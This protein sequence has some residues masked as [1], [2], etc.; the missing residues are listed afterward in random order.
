[1]SRYTGSARHKALAAFIVEKRMTAGLRQVDLA[2]R[3]K[4][5]QS[6]VTHIETGQKEVGVVELMEL[7][8]AIG[9]EPAEALKRLKRV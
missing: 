3:L 1:M 7:A 5:Y 4:R 2:K 9:F 6:Y 8:D